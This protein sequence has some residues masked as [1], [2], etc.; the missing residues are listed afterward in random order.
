MAE[1]KTFKWLDKTG[2]AYLWGKIKALVGTKAN[3]SDVYTKEEIDQMLEV[4]IKYEVV[5]QKPTE[6][7]KTGTIYLIPSTDEGEENAYDEFMYISGKW[8][9]IGSTK[10]DLSNYVEKEEGKGLSTNDFTDELKEKLEGIDLS[11]IVTGL[12]SGSDIELAPE[13]GGSDEKTITI[14]ANDGT[15]AEA[16]VKITLPEVEEVEVPV[17]G[18]TVNGAEVTPDENGIVAITTPEETVSDVQVILTEDGE[19]V[20]IVEEGIATIDLSV[21]QPKG[22]YIKAED[23]VAISND[24]IDEICDGDI[25]TPEEEQPEEPEEEEP[26]A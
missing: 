17:K 16:K 9:K 1:V 2:V 23:L 8:E 6:D 7:I 15:T 24:D 20:S 10:T 21:Y 3:I 22:D 14:T 5:D 19:G 18:I 26:N 4:G 25:N 12:E 11:E 13:F